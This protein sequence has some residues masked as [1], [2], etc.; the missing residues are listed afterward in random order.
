MGNPSSSVVLIDAVSSETVYTLRSLLL[1]KIPSPLWG[2]GR[3]R[4]DLDAA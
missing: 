3:V 4:G 1:M 2:E